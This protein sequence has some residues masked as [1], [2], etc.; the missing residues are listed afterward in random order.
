MSCS[1]RVTRR[2][3]LK[4]APLLAPPLVLGTA[5]GQ[6]AGEGL[7][8][9]NVVVFLTDQERATQHFPADWEKDNLPGLTRL[10]KAG[11]SFGNAFTNACMCSP[12]RSTWLSG[13]FPAQHGVKYTLEEN[14][15]ADKYPQV[16][17]PVGLKNLAT[18]MAAAGYT[19]VYK[20]KWHCNKPAG[21]RWVPADV[22]KY[23]FGRWN[24]QDAGA[25]QDLDQAGGGTA[26]N[27]GR[28][29]RDDGP[30]EEGKEGALAYLRSRAA[31]QQP[32]FLVV[33]LVNPHD[34]LFYPD[35]YKQAGYDDGWLRGPIGLP[36]TA[37]EDLATKP[38]AQQQFLAL[39]Q[40]LGRLDTPQKKRDYLNFYGSLLKASDKYLV[41]VLA[42]LDQQKLT[43]RTLV[44]RTADHGEMGLAHGGLRQKN[45][46]FYEESLR[47]PLVYSNPALFPAPRRSSALVS[48]VDFLP[49]LAALVTAPA[50][51]RADWQGV[52]YSRLVL[53][54]AA[55]PVQ[56]YVVF[57]YDDYQS[58]QAAP[59]FPQP[60]N[61]IVSLREARY[62][63]AEYYDPDGK[64]AGQWEMY[65]L[66]KDPAER[67][68]LAHDLDRQ[69]RE[70]RREYDRLRGKLAEVRAKRLRPLG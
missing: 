53:D 17:L 10:K 1:G 5:R 44:V 2:D 69:P 18:V 35:T 45:F 12:A 21:K 32:F 13:Y 34:V 28:F 59:V 70:V 3:V 39:S 57:T 60:P 58:G 37:D 41:E 31:G 30:W 29:M 25:N 9:M 33:S 61:R 49:T 50:A 65:D 38:T 20:G 26:D 6:P 11:L 62:K 43:D 47:V 54:P 40:F 66:E 7:A 23:G 36:P 55:P 15:P 4:S 27:D 19:V 8:G 42:A 16:E 67:A 24:P 51:A 56:D 63:L 52:D 14:M 68:N 46:N 64:A 48:H 22:G